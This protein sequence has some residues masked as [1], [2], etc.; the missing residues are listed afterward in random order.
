MSK[1]D[2]YKKE[3]LVDDKA[4]SVYSHNGEAL[5]D[6]DIQFKGEFV[7]SE[8]EK[9]LVRK[10][11]YT[12]LPFVFAC[13]FI[14][15]TDKSTLGIS[16]VLGI[17]QDTHLSGSQY[18]WLGSLFYLGFIC[19]QFPNSYL[20]QKFPISKYL[21]VILCFWGVVMACTALCHNFAQ[22]AVCRVLL[23][24]FE[25]ATYPCLLIIVNTVYRR[26]EQSAAYGFLWFSNGAGTI[27]GAACAYGIS[28][29]NNAHGI[30]SWRWPYIIWGAL[31]VVIGI[32]VFFFLPDTP[33]HFMFKLTEEEKKIV[34]ERIRDNAVVRVKEYKGSQVWE[35]IKEP[36][37]WLLAVSTLCNNLHNGGLVVFSTLIVSSFGF[38]VKYSI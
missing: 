4:A 19:F 36:R 18:S 31:T 32:V 16:A 13:V 2:T 15:F 27:L 38:S 8:A 6:D 12:L 14:Q 35:A 37:L 11:N 21:G 33:Y 7:K 29:I 17:I 28:Y 5:S 20:M 26:S 25:A 22:L 10:I 1:T 9:K 34:E 23:G 30:A 24:L 3:T